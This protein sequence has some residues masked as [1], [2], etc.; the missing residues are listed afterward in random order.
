MVHD[1]SAQIDTR[2][3]YRSMMLLTECLDS[4]KGLGYDVHETTKDGEIIID[5]LPALLKV[6]AD[7][8]VSGLRARGDFTVDMEWKAGQIV[9]AT[10]RSGRDAKAVIRANGKTKALSGTAGKSET[11]NGSE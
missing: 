1:R 7:G 9:K 6:W 11:I 3:R 4:P 10:L 2:L 8:R 5:L